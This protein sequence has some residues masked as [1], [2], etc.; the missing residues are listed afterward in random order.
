MERQDKVRGSHKRGMVSA[1][2]AGIITITVII[3]TI[4]FITRDEAE[5][6]A[7]VRIDMLMG[8]HEQY[9]AGPNRT[10]PEG[11]LERYPLA[12]ATREFKSGVITPQNLIPSLKT[13]CQATWDA[14][15][16]CVVSFKFDPENVYTGQWQPH[17]EQ[18]M[19]WIEDNKVSEQT[20]VVIW[21]EPEDDANDSFTGDKARGRAFADGET[22][23][24]YFNKVHGWI[25]TAN[26]RI[27]TSHAAL[28][29]GYRE[30][31]GGPGDKSAWVADPS[32]WITN[33]DI[34]GIDLYS[35]RSFP[36]EMTLETSTGFNRWKSTLPVGAKWGVSERGW[37]ADAGKSV[38][39]ANSIR[40]EFSWLAALPT[41]QLPA[42][43]L[44]WT[45]E[46]TENDPKIILDESGRLAV[47]EGFKS[48][49][50]KLTIPVEPLPE[51]SP[52]Q[53]MITCPLCHGEGEVPTDI[54]YSIKV[55]R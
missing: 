51:P 45:T 29:Y 1:I 20:I 53:S 34:H 8:V 13:L 9:Q 38:E 6:R 5:S 24:K 25:K 27:R 11:T 50:D 16:T 48:L 43:Y 26:P 30:K 15:M 3:V 12:R 55:S 21:H 17:I 40:A 31:R 19:R 37:I 44:V 49:T 41:D 22:F 46:G 2:I 33:A 47:N 35:G 42:Y 52:E 23:V 36:L 28:G 18:A 4:M 7:R 54:T 32:K 10:T 39:R 14:D